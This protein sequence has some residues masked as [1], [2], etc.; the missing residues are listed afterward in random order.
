MARKE[1][2]I[3]FKNIVALKT[4]RSFSRASLTFTK[5]SSSPLLGPSGCGKT[6]LH[7][8]RGLQPTGGQVLFDSEDIVNVP[9]YKR[10]STPYSRNTHSSH[11]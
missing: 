9:P 3:Q 5:M 6:T 8:R 11:T 2:I 10:E 7:P 1:K 4:D